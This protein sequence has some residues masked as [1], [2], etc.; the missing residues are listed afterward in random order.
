MSDKQRIF[1]KLSEQYIKDFAT[2]HGLEFDGW[3]GGGTEYIEVIAEFNEGL[4]KFKI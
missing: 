4:P 2:K 1:I 3:V